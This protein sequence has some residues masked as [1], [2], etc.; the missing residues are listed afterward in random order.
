MVQETSRQMLVIWENVFSADDFETVHRIFV[1]AFCFTGTA[2][3]SK[4][5]LLQFYS[6]GGRREKCVRYWSKEFQN[7]GMDILVTTALFGPAFQKMAWTKHEQKYSFGKPMNQ[8]F[9]FIHRHGDVYQNSGHLCP[10]KIGSHNSIFMLRVVMFHGKFTQH[11]S[12][13]T[14]YHQICIYLITSTML[15]DGRG[16]N[17]RFETTLLSL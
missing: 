2:S 16:Q 6:E 5:S 15:R 9:G 3:L 11:C 8:N 10:L 7:G 12:C 1:K 14:R 4:W 17:R 13:R